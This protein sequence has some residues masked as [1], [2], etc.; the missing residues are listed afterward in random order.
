MFSKI[1][2]V[3]CTEI[4]AGLAD[5]FSQAASTSHFVTTISTCPPKHNDHGGKRVTGLLT[6]SGIYQSI[7]GIKRSSDRMYHA[8]MHCIALT[9][10]F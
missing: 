1:I 6:E 5:H 8:S 3:R 7:C 10:F 9:F 2:E 4:L